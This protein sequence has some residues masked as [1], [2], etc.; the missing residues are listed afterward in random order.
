MDKLKLKEHNGIHNNPLLTLL[1][2]HSII[3]GYVSKSILISMDRPTDK[4][5]VAKRLKGVADD[6][7]HSVPSRKATLLDGCDKEASLGDN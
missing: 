5:N 1:W 4:P 7:G 2:T 6:V 3:L